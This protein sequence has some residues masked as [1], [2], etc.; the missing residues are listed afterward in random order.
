MRPSLSEAA[1]SANNPLYP[2]YRDPIQVRSQICNGLTL[3]DNCT[4]SLKLEQMPVRTLPSAYQDIQSVTYTQGSLGDVLV[5][6]AIAPVV[7]FVPGVP[8][9]SVKSPASWLTR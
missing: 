5:I 6:R 7:T 2:Q 1:G 3:V 9:L 8:Q 4:V